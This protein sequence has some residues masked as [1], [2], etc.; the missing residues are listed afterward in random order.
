MKD[1]FKLYLLHKYDPVYISICECGYEYCKPNH[2]VGPVARDYYLLHFIIEGKGYYKSK[3]Y[4]N[5][6]SGDVF[7]IKPGETIVYESDSENPWT[8]YWI[9]FDSPRI[10]NLLNKLFGNSYSI[11]LDEIDWVKKIFVEISNCDYKNEVS[12][13]YIT[14]KLYEIIYYLFK[15][16]NL[17]FA[18]TDDDIISKIVVYINEHIG[19][20]LSV[21]LIC[22]KFGFS[23]SYIFILFK[24]TM[25]ISMK[26]F[27]VKS[28]MDRACILL[29]QNNSLTV[30]EVSWLVGYNN[31]QSFFKTFKKRFH[32]SPNEIRKE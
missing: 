23:R 18:P 8:Y 26:E 9:G 16:N 15:N 3:E 22:E 4:L 5:L 12:Q 2:K 21:N 29:Q 14:S 10:K 25:G 20:E 27:I 13:F 19:D 32:V 1:K 24:E 30:K 6:S 28:K 11:H 31:Y 7:L 17:H